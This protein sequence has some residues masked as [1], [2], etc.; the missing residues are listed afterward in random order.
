MI[1]LK[2]YPQGIP[3]SIFAKED[4]KCLREKIRE[5]FFSRFVRDNILLP[6]SKAD[7]LSKFYQLGTVE[8]IEYA[9][10]GIHISHAITQTNKKILNS[11]LKS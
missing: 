5:H 10:D 2:S 11:L 4:V 6:Y 1:L 9:E 7:L 3:V 8:G